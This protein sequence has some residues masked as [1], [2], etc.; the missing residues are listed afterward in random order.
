[1]R[2]FITIL[3]MLFIITAV[4][5][6]DNVPEEIQAL[7]SKESSGIQLTPSEKSQVADYLARLQ[8]S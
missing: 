4:V 6:A 5:M 3:A 1:M 2:N 7:L 8:L